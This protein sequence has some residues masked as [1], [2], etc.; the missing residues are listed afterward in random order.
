M[1]G[2]PEIITAVHI[3]SYILLAAGIMIQQS[4]PSECSRFGPQGDSLRVDV[5]EM[6]I[7]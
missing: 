5:G 6:K 4:Y 3:V 2:L 1:Y 7:L